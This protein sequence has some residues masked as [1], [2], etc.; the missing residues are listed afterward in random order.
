MMRRTLTTT[1]VALA[2]AILA[3]LAAAQD[4]TPPADA[5]L[6]RGR[7]LYLEASFPEAAQAFQAVV[8]REGVDDATA[9]EA[10]RYLAVLE[11]IF[12]HPDVAR[13][14]ARAALELDRD[15]TPPEGA[16]EEA[17][18]MFDE[19]RASLPPPG[20]EPEPEPE[21]EGAGFGSKWVTL[22]VGVG[23][24]VPTIINDMLPHVTFGIDAGL[25]LPFHDRRLS[26]TVGCAYSPPGVSDEGLEDPRLGQDGGT[27]SYEMQTHEIFVSLGLVYRILPPGVGRIWPYVGLVAR[28]YMLRTNVSGV[29]AG[30]EFGENTEQSTQF[31]GALQ[32]GAEVRLGPGAFWFELAF[33]ISDL[34]HT[35]TGDTNTGA[36]ALNLGYRFF[37]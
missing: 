20:A 37:I 7:Q 22:G 25:L 23:V 32:A 16:P 24:Y 27:W 3:P 14:H 31:G 26:V 4:A 28:L 6:E 10:Y 2:L 35:I 18:S 29:G 11:L 9:R 13:Q 34:P 15:S 12:D 5:N 36:L 8:E 33:S 30:A 1:A 21:P 19:L 17:V